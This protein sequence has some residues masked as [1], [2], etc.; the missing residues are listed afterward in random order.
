[1]PGL[2]RA[3]ALLEQYE[4]ADKSNRKAGTGRMPQAIVK[5]PKLFKE[6]QQNRAKEAYM[7]LVVLSSNVKFQRVHMREYMDL[8]KYLYEVSF[9]KPSYTLSA[10][11][12]ENLPLN[13][14]FQIASKPELT[15]GKTA[16][17][18]Q[19]TEGISRPE[20]ETS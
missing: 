9:G 13:V 2:P 1:M 15:D 6:F 19:I 17:T 5:D 18:R 3:E 14:T 12:G 11:L 8:C 16:N 20:K 4:S 10:D 7:K